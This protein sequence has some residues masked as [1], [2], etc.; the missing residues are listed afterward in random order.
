[1]ETNKNNSQLKKLGKI[2][3]VIYVEDAEGAKGSGTAAPS[4]GEKEKDTQGAVPAVTSAGAGTSH[5]GQSPCVPQAGSHQDYKRVTILG[6]W[7]VANTINWL[8]KTA[9]KRP[10]MG[11]SARHKD[12]AT[13]RFLYIYNKEEEEGGL[14][15][16]TPKRKPHRQRFRGAR[17][18][19]DLESW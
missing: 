15:C 10:E 2:E 1:M 17:R 5:Q 9:R 16:L 6:R 7:K 4:E 19:T 14:A 12:N 13:A 11:K 3:G 8:T 18:L